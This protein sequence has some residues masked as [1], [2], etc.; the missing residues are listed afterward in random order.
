MAFFISL[1]TQKAQNQKE[2]HINFEGLKNL[3]KGIFNVKFRLNKHDTWESCNLRILLSVGL[4]LVQ[5]DIKRGK[6]F[7]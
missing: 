3:I 2:G 4:S 6:T 5:H 7:E 1:L